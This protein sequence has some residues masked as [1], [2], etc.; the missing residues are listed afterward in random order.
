MQDKPMAIAMIVLTAA[1]L[2]GGAGVVSADLPVAATAPASAPAPGA[3]A[4]A[5]MDEQHQAAARKLIQ[6]GIDFL[7]PR[8]QADGGWS[9]GQ[10]AN[11]PAIT[12]MV[13]KALI[14]GGHL[15]DRSQWVQRGFEV[16]LSYRQAD[17]GIYDPKQGLS[18][19]TTSLAIMAMTASQ[20]PRYTQAIR[21]SVEYLKRQQIAPGAETPD[22]Q[23]VTPDHPFAGGVSYGQHGRPDLSNMGMWMEAMH[24]AGVPADDPAIQRALVF[25]TRAQ[26][27]SESNALAWAKE[28]SNDGG[29]VYAPATASILVQGETKVE[30]APGETGLRSYGSMTYVGFKSLLYAGL[31]KDDGRVRA[32]YDWIR[33]YWRLDSNPNMPRAQSLQGLYYYYHAMAKALRAWGEPVITDAQGVAHL[34]RAELIDALQQRVRPDGSWVNLAM[35]WEEADPVLATAYAVLA[36]QETLAP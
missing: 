26:N 22:G 36:L 30:A 21:E 27:R 14:Q 13:L 24:E 35:R 2:A 31:A 32:A 17:G 16:M 33:R 4:P 15:N 34:W 10:G 11:K 8:Q 3:S 29:F 20:N 9:L 23:T 25:V 7:R 18:N 28:G 12:A 19:Y 1:V 5:G 6:G